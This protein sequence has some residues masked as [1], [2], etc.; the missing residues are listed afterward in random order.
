MSLTRFEVLVVCP[1]V[2]LTGTKII[3]RLLGNSG[4]SRQAR[5]SKGRRALRSSGHPGRYMPDRRGL[6]LPAH[7]GPDTRD[8]RGRRRLAHPGRGIWSPRG[9]HSIARRDQCMRDHRG[10]CMQARLA[11]RSKVRQVLCFP[12]SCIRFAR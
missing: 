4:P 12:D 1:R 5:S 2:V 10:R 6:G 9:P 7:L 3:C 11:L 8:H